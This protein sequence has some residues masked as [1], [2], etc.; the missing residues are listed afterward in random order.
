MEKIKTC[1]N[2]LSL[3]VSTYIASIFENFKDTS[4]NADWSSVYMY[5]M[6][7]SVCVA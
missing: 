4:I 6:V 1:F 2:L 5:A 7:C 3:K